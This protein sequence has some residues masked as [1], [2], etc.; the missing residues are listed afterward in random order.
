MSPSGAGGKHPVSSIPAEQVRELRE[1]VQELRV[2]AEVLANAQA[3]QH[4][5]HVPAGLLDLSER[6][7]Q[8]LVALEEAVR[9][10]AGSREEQ[11]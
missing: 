7:D 10:S 9:V 5:A 4:V 1:K 11:R 2:L 6:M 3:W 8:T